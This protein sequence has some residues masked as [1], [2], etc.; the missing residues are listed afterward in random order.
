LRRLPDERTQSRFGITARLPAAAGGGRLAAVRD[1][2][3]FW[4]AVAAFA[5]NVRLVA[6]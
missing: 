6:R 2:V 3:Q 1:D 4:F 5:L